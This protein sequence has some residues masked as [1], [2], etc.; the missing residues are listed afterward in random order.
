MTD[1]EIAVATF[2]AVAALHYAFTG[3]PLTLT[4]ETDCG[5][6]SVTEPP[7][8]ASVP[9]CEGPGHSAKLYA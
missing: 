8:E 1:R 4:I 7:A 6:V 9:L 2:K 5:A 3:K